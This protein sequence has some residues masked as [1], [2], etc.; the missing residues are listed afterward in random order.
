MFGVFL[1]TTQ[2]LFRWLPTF[3]AFPLGGLLA[4]LALGP[5]RDPLAAAVSGALVGCTLGLMQWWALRPMGISFDWVWSTG[6]ALMIGSPLAWILRSFS[7]TIPSLTIWGLIAGAIVGLAQ[8]L[9]QRISL[10]KAVSWTA[11]VSGSWGLAWFISANVIVDA[12]ANYAVFGST[13]AIVSTLILS[14]FL[15]PLLA[16]KK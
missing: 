5:I 9:S 16:K 3:L 6:V 8:S 11:L 4:V 14:F 7:T 1:K 10:K 13:G 15:N 2:I 12:D